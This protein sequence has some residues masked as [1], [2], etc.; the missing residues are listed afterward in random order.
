MFPNASNEEKAIMF[1][2]IRGNKAPLPPDSVISAPPATGRHTTSLPTVA[3]ATL[4]TT[5]TPLVVTL[6]SLS[7]PLDTWLVIQLPPLLTACH[8]VH[9]GA[10]WSYTMTLP[11]GDTDGSS[12]TPVLVTR[13]VTPEFKS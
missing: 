4:Y 10:Q 8:G 5:T 13:T 2:P 11:S 6:G 1:P 3:L 12:S 7:I 9:D